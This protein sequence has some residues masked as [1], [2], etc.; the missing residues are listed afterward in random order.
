MKTAIVMLGLSGVLS[1]CVSEKA[2]LTNRD[3]NVVHCDNWGFG[4][5]G[6]P[7]ALIGHH[8]CVARAK[9]AGYSEFPG[10]TAPPTA[11]K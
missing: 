1:A 9:A 10:S 7:V 8:N 5:I 4:I 11:A 6:T 3:G 2:A